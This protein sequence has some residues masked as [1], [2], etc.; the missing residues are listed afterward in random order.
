MR[1]LQLA[2]KTIQY[3]NKTFQIAYELT[4]L[5]NQQT[6]V[7]LHGWGSNK[8][9]MKQAF[10]NS[11]SE[12][13][14]LYIDMPGF[15]K[16]SNQYILTTKDYAKIMQEFLKN[17]NLE[18]KAIAGHSF[19]GK[20]ATLLN[21]K[22]LILL[23]SAG[24]IEEKPLGVKCKIAFVKVLGKLGLKGITKV[25]R[26]NDVN[27]MSE[28][29][30]GTF[31]NV[32]D[33]DFTNSFA[34]FENFAIILWG[35]DDAATS[36]KSGEQIDHLIKNSFFKVYEGDHYFFLHHKQDIENSIRGN[37]L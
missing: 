19:G 21:P 17:L 34:K 1:G 27:T 30:Y 6:I 35:K 36:L 16:S 10:D 33:E 5:S 18:I 12:Y 26:S 24:I 32:V 20:V 7:F 23:S 14:H 31:K 9:I 3:E 4:N 13:K 37:L 25:F 22:N 28:S 8:E 2:S 29:M 15:G 11:L